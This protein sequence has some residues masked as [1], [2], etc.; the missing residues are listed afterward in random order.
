MR[1]NTNYWRPPAAATRIKDAINTQI[2]ILSIADQLGL[3]YEKHGRGK[4]RL[5]EHDSCII[6]MDQ[7]TFSRYSQVNENGKVVGGG[8]LDFYMHFADKKYFEALHD[9]ESQIDKGVIV[10]STPHFDEPVLTPEKRHRQ[11]SRKLSASLNRNPDNASMHQVFA[12]LIKTRKID[13]EI[14]HAFVEQKCLFQISGEKGHAQCAFVGHNEKGLISAV[15]FRGTSSSVRFMGDFEGCDYDRGWYFDPTYDLQQRA[16]EKKPIEPK[17][18]MLLC[19]ESVIEAM[20]YMS[21]LKMGGYPWKEFAY[22]ATGSITKTNAVFE[23]VKLYDPKEV[24]MMYNND[25]EEEKKAGRNPGKQAAEIV[26]GKLLD[27][28]VKAKVLLPEKANDWNDTLKGVIA[29][30]IHLSK[31]NRTQENQERVR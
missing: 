15:C 23:T 29:G 8:P 10:E 7:N 2:D 1:K 3:E 20:S 24:V 21:I 11:L 18:K 25:M 16:Y 13:Q 26:A 6:N 31:K 5:V 28:G 19:F 30:T 27:Q 4:V 9:L 22:L 17:R 14:V 12:Y